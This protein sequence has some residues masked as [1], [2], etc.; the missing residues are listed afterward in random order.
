V[1]IADQTKALYRVL[2]HG[3]FDFVGDE[4]NAELLLAF[5]GV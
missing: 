1:Q 2:Y 4:I 5:S 3:C